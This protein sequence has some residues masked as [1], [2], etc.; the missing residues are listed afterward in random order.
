MRGCSRKS[1]N[2][3]EGVETKGGPQVQGS[4]HQT[5][6]GCMLTTLNVSLLKDLVEKD[7]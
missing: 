1:I 4:A 5:V 3:D 7:M 6:S 2:L